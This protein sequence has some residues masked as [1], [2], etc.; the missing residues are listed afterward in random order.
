MGMEFKFG[1]TVPNTRGIGGSIKLA[2][3]EN[4]GTSTATFSKASGLTT[5]L[6]GMVFTFIKMA[7]GMREN[8]KM[9]CSTEK[10]KR[11]GQTRPCMR[12]TTMKAKSTGTVCISGKMDPSMRETGMKTELKDRASTNG[13]MVGAI[14]DNGKTII[15]MV[16]EFTLGLM[17][18]ATKDNTKW[19]R[20]TVSEFTNGLTD[21]FMRV[22]GTTENNTGKENMCS[23]T[24][25]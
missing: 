16:K 6:T 5:K 1:R 7:Q 11:F 13:K 17:E 24:E 15:C 4:S 2:D 14:M 3:T 21:E 22:I 20:S 19:I 10:A 25:P 8:G 23:K 12:D 9:I 18:D